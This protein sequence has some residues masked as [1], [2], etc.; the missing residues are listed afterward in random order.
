MTQRREYWFPAKRYGYGWGPPKVW[1]GWV[2]LAIFIALV[3]LGALTL[4]P[5]HGAPVFLGYV[6]VLVAALI[7]ICYFKGEPPEWR[8]PKR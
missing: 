7:A 5:H 4:L 8:W 3:A 1:Q 6:L 2:V